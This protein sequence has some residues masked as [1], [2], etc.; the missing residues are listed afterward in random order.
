MLDCRLPRM[1]EPEVA[2]V[3]RRW[4]SLTEQEQEVLTLVA[5]GR[6]N[7]EIAR[8]LKVTERTVEF[9]LGHIL[10]KLGVTSRLEAVVGVK[11]HGMCE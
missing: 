9:H 2:P 11:E 1:V 5:E 7:K 6:N 10:G 3:E 8:A 4:G